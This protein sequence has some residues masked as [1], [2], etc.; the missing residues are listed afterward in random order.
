MR[1]D[2]QVAMTIS[3]PIVIPTIP[4]T[5]KRRF[6]PGSAVYSI[7]FTDRLQFQISQQFSVEAQV[8]GELLK[9]SLHFFNS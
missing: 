8:F 5:R 6:W 7:G 2:I 3:S 1:I 4:V 9:I